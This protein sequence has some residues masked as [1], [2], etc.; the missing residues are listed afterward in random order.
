MTYKK[1]YLFFWVFGSHEHG[2]HRLHL[3][4]GVLRSIIKIQNWTMS[5]TFSVVSLWMTRSIRAIMKW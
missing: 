3:F 5:L 1:G 2:V 4:A